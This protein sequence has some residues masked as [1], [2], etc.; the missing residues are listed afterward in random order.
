MCGYS[1]GD[2][3]TVAGREGPNLGLAELFFVVKMDHDP[4]CDS[5]SHTRSAYHSFFAFENREY[6]VVEDIEPGRQ[7]QKLIGSDLMYGFQCD[8][9]IGFK[10]NDPIHYYLRYSTT[11][12]ATLL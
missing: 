1:K 12:F 10:S 11:C 3:R 5:H 7:E 2:A 9:I 8:Q 6:E 4:F